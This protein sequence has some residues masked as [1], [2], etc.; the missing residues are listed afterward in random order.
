MRRSRGLAVSGQFWIARPNLKFLHRDDLAGKLISVTK[1]VNTTVGYYCGPSFDCECRA[2][3]LPLKRQFISSI[4]LPL[5]AP[6]ADTSCAK[7][8]E[9]YS[10]E[11]VKSIQFKSPAS[12]RIE[13]E[14]VRVSHKDKCHE[15]VERQD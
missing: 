13:H 5:Q 8:E 9:T 7:K 15:K 10:T 14:K 12:S 1:S 2:F 4:K 6:E 11:E 3:E